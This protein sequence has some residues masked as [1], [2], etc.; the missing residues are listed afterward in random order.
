MHTLSSLTS[1]LHSYGILMHTR[2]Q[3]ISKYWLSTPH[4]PLT[5]AYVHKTIHFEKFPIIHVQYLNISLHQ[6]Y[7]NSHTYSMQTL[8]CFNL[9]FSCISK[10]NRFIGAA[11]L[12]AWDLT[13]LVSLPVTE[14]GGWRSVIAALNP[15][16][17]NGRPSLF[18]LAWPRGAGKTHWLLAG[19]FTQRTMAWWTQ[20]Y[21]TR[22]LL[23]EAIAWGRTTLH[24]I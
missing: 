20:Y 14:R 18:W 8:Y 9:P 24:A 19:S 1:L 2:V 12:T 10:Q 17:V 6:P 23:Y 21:K 13:M 4:T 7:V 3:V 16:T 15:S 22:K 11:F 5:H